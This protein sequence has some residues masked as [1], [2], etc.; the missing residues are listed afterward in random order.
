MNR[1][2]QDL[3]EKKSP[4]LL[5]VVVFIIAAILL[6]M[7]SQSNNH[8]EIKLIDIPKEKTTADSEVQLLPNGKAVNELLRSEADQELESENNSETPFK[9][10]LLEESDDSVRKSVEN[11]SEHL[12]DWFNVKHIIRKYLVIINDLSQNQIL[13]KHRKFLK[14]SQKIVVKSDSRGL[15]LAQE[16][17]DRYNGLANA[18]AD[19]NTKKGIDL[20]LRFKPL[21]EQVYEEFGYP[22][23][24]RLED[25]FM[26][27]AASVLKAPRQKG[28]IALVQHSLRY[29]YADKKLEALN[30]VEKQMLRM[31]PEN[32]KKIQD[33]LRQLVEA[34]AIINE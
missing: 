24:Y 10:P 29:K 30:D 18:I 14:I 20:F 21:F 16:S 25:I 15:Y 9:V 19:I 8:T 17:Y 3:N 13:Y 11:V 34:I 28:R 23:E 22:E 12:L 6:Y 1:Y 27:A 2:G 4:V 31:G 33:K 26:K 32:T 7:T 5:I